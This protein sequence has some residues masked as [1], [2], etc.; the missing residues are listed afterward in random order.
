MDENSIKFVYGCH[1]CGE[2]FE[3]WAEFIKHYGMCVGFEV[4]P[5]IVENLVS[6]YEEHE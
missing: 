3:D 4:K 6:N 5:L 2:A 1:G